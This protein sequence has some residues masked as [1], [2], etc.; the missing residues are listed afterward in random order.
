VKPKVPV[1]HLNKISNSLTVL[2]AKVIQAAKEERKKLTTFKKVK[3]LS[4]IG[5]ASKTNVAGALN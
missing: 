2:Q 4:V 3:A 1:K 5:K